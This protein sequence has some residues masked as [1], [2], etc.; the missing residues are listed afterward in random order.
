MHG[1]ETAAY[2]RMLNYFFKSDGLKLYKTTRNGL[3]GTEYSSKFSIWL[4]L[5]S[6]SP[7]LLYLKV[8]EFESQ[9]QANESTKHFVFELLWRDFF[10]FHTLKFGKKIF[11]LNGLWPNHRTWKWKNDPVLFE[12][13]CKGAAKI[14]YSYSRIDLG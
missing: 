4:S 1:G 14:C 2:E 12:K 5:G 3:V 9:K 13:W 11:Y 7:R 8:K 10:K 6:I